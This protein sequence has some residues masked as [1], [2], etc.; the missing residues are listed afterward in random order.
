MAK[1]KTVNLSTRSRQR[2]IKRL[3]DFKIE[4]PSWGFS[5]QG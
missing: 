3:L 5:V 2:I 4:V 1:K